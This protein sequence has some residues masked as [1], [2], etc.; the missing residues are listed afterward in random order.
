MDFEDTEKREQ[1]ARKYAAEEAKRELSAGQTDGMTLRERFQRA[2]HY[3]YVDVLPNFEFGY[4]KQTLSGWHAQGLPD[5]V[6]DETTAYRYFGIE[7]YRTMGVKASH[8]NIFE[9]A[10]L[11]ETEDTIVKRNE[12]GA[13]F[14]SKKTGHESIPHYLEYAVR[15]WETWKPFREHLL[16]Q[17]DKLPRNWEERVREHDGR[18]YPLGIDFG[19]LIGF[20]R[21]LMGFENTALMVCT[22]PEL[23]EDMVETFCVNSYGKLEKALKYLQF[24]FAAGW[25][26]ICFNSGP[27]VGVNF[28]RDVLAPRY[29]RIADLLALHGVD[30]VNTDCDGNLSLVVEHFLAG[31]VNTMFPVEVHGGTDPVELRR[32]FGKRLRFW[33]GVDKMIFLKDKAAVDKEL[34]R[35][36]PTVE[37]GGFI[38]T[39]D[40]RVQAD[41]QLDLYKHYLDRKRE[42]FK[43][44]G[45]PMY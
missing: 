7:T 30:I 34:E 20:P 21:N 23:M 28:F 40:H 10:V 26:D 15:D 2:M 41:A 16:A 27:I 1:E 45:E 12:M 33:G 22:E 18:D 44:G 24:D 19:S 43:C 14:E 6:I 25:E 5:W 17:A 42:W 11:S 13:V 29:K 32:K 31:G 39:V 8:C 35:I 37:E 36:R 9:P 3:Q 38:P 4:W